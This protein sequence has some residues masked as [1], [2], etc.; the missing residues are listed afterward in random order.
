VLVIQKVANL[1]LLIFLLLVTSLL[2]IWDRYLKAS[3]TFGL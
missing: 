3:L 2:R 1:G